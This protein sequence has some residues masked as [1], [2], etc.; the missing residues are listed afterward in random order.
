M[1]FLFLVVN[2]NVLFITLAGFKDNDEET[3]TVLE[4]ARAT[5]K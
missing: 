5:E 1:I 2:I 3:P 4:T